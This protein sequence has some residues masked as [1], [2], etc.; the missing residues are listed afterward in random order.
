MTVSEATSAA[1]AAV[2]TST[3]VV[4]PHTGWALL[5]VGG[6]DAT[7]FL[8]GQLSSDVEALAP[9]EGHYWSYNSPKGRML[10]NG[11]LWRAPAGVFDGYYMLA[12]ADLAETLRRRLSMFVLRAKVSIDDAT[13]TH[14]VIGLA[15]ARSA[16]AARDALGVAAAPSRAVAVSAGATA[17]TLPDRRIVVVAPAASGPIVQ[18][19]LARHARVA[20]ADT[21]RFAGIVAG[22]PWIGA[23]TSDLFVAQAL[24][25]DVLGG[26]AFRKGC[27]PGQEIIARMQY[28]GRLK[29]R[30]F[31]YWTEATGVAPATRVH[32]PTFE[33]AQPCGTVVDA[34]PDPAGGT[35]LLAV[36]QLAAADADDL[37]LGAPGGPALSRRP[38][39]YDVPAAAPREPRP[40]AG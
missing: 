19:A 14:V 26:V 13:R 37:A 40:L 24:N 33:A 5:A 16:E 12:A 10:A 23:A 11:A 39:P 25:F 9:G 15:G 32:S 21:W 30:L 28:L 1:E 18:A 29:E 35:A 17:F 2:P 20:D 34:A 22:V 7:A 4:C 8:H 31:A 38:L 27:Y 36:V 3:P 6:S